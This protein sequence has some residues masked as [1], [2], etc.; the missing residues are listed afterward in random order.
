MAL[1]GTIPVFHPT[2]E[3]MADFPAYIRGM[4]A[5]GAH[6]IGLAKVLV[7]PMLPPSF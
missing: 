5:R 4:E 7:N 3:E 1:R 6:E 2:L